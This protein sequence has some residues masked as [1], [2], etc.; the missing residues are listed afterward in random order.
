MSSSTV[1]EQIVLL[2]RVVDTVYVRN[3][4]DQVAQL[5]ELT[6]ALHE[7]QEVVNTVQ[8]HLVE[9]SRDQSVRQAM[10]LEATYQAL[11]SIEP[12]QENVNKVAQAIRR[13][14]NL[15]NRSST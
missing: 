4:E 3:L 13:G 10:L 1:A 12:T 2:D 6:S 11:I 5:V 8:R 9:N 15:S 7:N 14:M